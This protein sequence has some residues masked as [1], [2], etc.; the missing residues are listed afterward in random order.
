VA[1]VISDPGDRPRAKA[2][3]LPTGVHRLRHTHATTLLEQNVPIKAVAERL[4]HASATVTLNVYAH[5]TQRSRDE[6]LAA[7]DVRLPRPG[8]LAGDTVVPIQRSR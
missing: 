6:A 4:G 8:S 7:L 2:L 1:T 5:V 3:R